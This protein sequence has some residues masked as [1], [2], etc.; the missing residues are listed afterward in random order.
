MRV[1]EKVV[2]DTNSQPSPATTNR[3][4]LIEPTIAD[5]MFLAI[6]TPG[7]DGGT[8]LNLLVWGAPGTGKTATSK[9]VIARAGRSAFYVDLS[10]SAPEDLAGIPRVMFAEV[11]ED[12]RVLH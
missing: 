1:R 6:T 9:D 8:G 7:Y 10:L 2:P 12:G 3:S 11:S 4:G 5:A